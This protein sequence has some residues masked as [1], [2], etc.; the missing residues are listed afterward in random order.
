MKVTCIIASFNRPTWVRQAIASVAQQTHKNYQ[1]IVADESDVF[2]IEEAVAEFALTEVVVRKSP[3]EPAQRRMQNRLSIKCNLGLSLATGDL[4]CFLCDDDY[5]YPEW[6]AHASAFFDANPNVGAG[7]GRL[8]YHDSREMV[9]PENPAP[10]NVRFF[11]GVLTDPFDKLDHNQ[12][13]HR[14]L[15]PPCKWPEDPGTIGGPDAYYYREVSRRY[16]FHAIDAL[17][18][19]KRVHKKNLQ[20]GVA[21]YMDGTMDVVRE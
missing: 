9:Y 17:A 12:G 15:D 14:R 3:V 4:V 19:V 13:I 10:V 6:F 7:Y 18:A 16:K 1:L 11:P 20:S 21:E 2:D 8:I 5:L